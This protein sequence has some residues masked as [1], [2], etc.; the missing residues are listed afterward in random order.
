MDA[1]RD[2]LVEAALRL[3]RLLDLSRDDLE[4]DESLAVALDR[5]VQAADRYERLGGSTG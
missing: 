2:D 5:L 3:R 1:A 4:A